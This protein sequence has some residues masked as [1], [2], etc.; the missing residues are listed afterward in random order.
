MVWTI[1]EIRAAWAQL[2]VARNGGGRSLWVVCLASD[3]TIKVFFGVALLARC[4][5]HAHVLTCLT[6]KKQYYY[7][8]KRLLR[9]YE[10]GTDDL[11]GEN[12]RHNS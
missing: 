10:H 7:G 12:V 1:D 3:E 4:A 5:F 2:N 9:C 11:E 8:R 6:L